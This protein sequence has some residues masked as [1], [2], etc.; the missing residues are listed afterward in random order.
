M[1]TSRQRAIL[2]EAGNHPL[3]LTPPSFTNN[4]L[5]SAS[6]RRMMNRLCVAGLVR[7]Y[8]HGDYVITVEGRDALIRRAPAPTAGE[9]K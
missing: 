7:P 1:V 8:V 4:G 5:G 9:E 2:K 6:R 3:G